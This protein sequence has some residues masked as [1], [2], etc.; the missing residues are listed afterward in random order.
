VA[1]NAGP[2]ALAKEASELTAKT[3]NINTYAQHI[4]MAP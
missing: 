4:T 3:P 1:V 2:F